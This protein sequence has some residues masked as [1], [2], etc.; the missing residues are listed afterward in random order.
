MKTVV[1]RLYVAINIKKQSPMQ[2]LPEKNTFLRDTLK[3]LK[4]KHI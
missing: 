4:H 3:Y 1:K 2:F